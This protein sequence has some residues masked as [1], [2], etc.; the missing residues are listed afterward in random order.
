MHPIVAKM[1]LR[2]AAVI[3]GVVLTVVGAAWV[4][5][6]RLDLQR[7][8]AHTVNLA[9]RQRALFRG[10]HLNLLAL[11]S[12]P[13]EAA[14]DLL[15]AMTRDARESRRVH[16]WL[17]GDPPAP[18]VTP[19]GLPVHGDMVASYRRALD[20]V[21]EQRAG[22]FHAVEQLL[23]L[24]EPAGPT[25]RQWAEAAL[26]ATERDRIITA[27]DEGA[28]AVAAAATRR[29]ARL[30]D[31][32]WLLTA[33]QLAVMGCGVFFV[34]LPLLRRVGASVDELEHDRRELADQLT[35]LFELSND[36]IVM[37]GPDLRFCRVNPAM[38]GL[39]GYSAEELC[40]RPVTD[41]VHPDDLGGLLGVSDDVRGGRID[42]VS[43][44]RCRFR[45]KSGDWRLL[46]GSAVYDPVAQVMLGIGRDITDEAA[47][48][49]EMARYLSELE[50]SNRSLDEFAYAASHDL[51][52]PLRDVVNLSAWI[53]EDLG[54]DLPPATQRHIETMQQRV[55]RMDELL[56]DLLRY[57]RAGRPGGDVEEFNLAEA[58]SRAVQQ[59]GIP[60]GF[61]VVNDAPDVLVSTERVPL[62]QVLRN[63][64]AN[65]VKH[66]DRR[67]GRIE[68]SARIDGETLIVRVTDDG[69]G[70]DPAYHDRIF[71]MF[72]TLRPKGDGAGSGIGLAIVRKTI[73]A[74]GGAVA[75]R[76]QV[77]AGAT[78][79]FTW[80]LD[81]AAEPVENAGERGAA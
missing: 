79:E 72:Q 71:R 76:S 7:E 39:L 56:D 51:K 35:R 21:S 26:G 1:A 67:A 53:A 50:R 62:E 49:E 40:S 11:K 55:R 10:L 30:S 78:F 20:P 29:I 19:P 16:A 28:A 44:F 65:A 33:A 80:G 17:A 2:F 68:V 59:V 6:Y 63:L 18:G 5:Q 75:V 24:S 43:N 57:A 8:A 52:S 15:A 38:I 25:G 9:G 48:L 23:G 46:A 32:L 42:R 13:G 22:F 45:T 12:G 41:F 77:G 31:L 64:I 27:L 54:G 69:P 34:I 37:S 4:Q 73:E 66:H 36:V 70:I 60:E 81:M 14:P 58:V 3:T 47:V 61:H 74:H